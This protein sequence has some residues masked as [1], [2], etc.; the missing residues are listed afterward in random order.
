VIE[1]RIE[2]EHD[3]GDHHLVVGRVLRMQHDERR[4]PLVFYRSR[5]AGL[6]EAERAV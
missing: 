5:F 1:C 4:S 6:S 2:A 3:A